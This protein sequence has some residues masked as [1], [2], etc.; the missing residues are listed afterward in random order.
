MLVERLVY[1]FTSVLLT[2]LC[3]TF[4]SELCLLGVAKIL[5]SPTLPGFDKLVSPALARKEHVK[6]LETRNA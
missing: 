5:S 2:L 4:G 1:L 3:A 6:I